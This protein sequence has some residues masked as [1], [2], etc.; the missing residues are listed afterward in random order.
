MSDFRSKR[1]VC[2]I[3]GRNLGDIVLASSFLKNLAQRNFADEYVAWTR[4]DAAFLFS[5]IPNCTTVT[6]SFPV[7]TTKA[8][9]LKQFFR[10]LQCVRIIR[11]RQPSVT[12]DLIGDFRERVFAKLVKSRQHLQINWGPGHPFVNL[13]RIPARIS[14]G[15]LSIPNTLRN[16]YDSHSMFLDSIS[17]SVES[18]E[19]SPDPCRT[20]TRHFRDR[21]HIGI[22]MYASQLS[23][24]WPDSHWRELV[25]QLLIRGFKLTVFAS[26]SEKPNVISSLGELSDHVTISARPL[27]EFFNSLKE[28]DF[29]IGVDSVAVH[30]AALLGKGTLTI[31]SGNP[32]DMW[33]PPH[34]TM[35]SSSGNC[36]HYPCYNRA[37]C[38]ETSQPY[39]CIRSITPSEV[40]RVLEMRLAAMRFCEKP[41]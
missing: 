4:P 24:L 2:I 20:P 29:L 22:H 1:T 38:A 15:T 34:G 31:N 27:P 39:V 5:G 11:K 9:D 6:C 30:M 17:S 8:F 23:K 28:V 14:E 32:P 25:R 41:A 12:I 7:G 3:A 21:V 35:L 13:I 40:L 26:P 16:V 18:T 19:S 36:V 37:P 33:T 10:F